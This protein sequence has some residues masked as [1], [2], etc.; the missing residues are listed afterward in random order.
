MISISGSKRISVS[1]DTSNL[2][3]PGP[4]GFEVRNG[5]DI[6]R[7]ANFETAAPGANITATP[8][9]VIAPDSYFLLVSWFPSSQIINIGLEANLE[10]KTIP[11]INKLL[12]SFDPEF[13]PEPDIKVRA[14][15]GIG[16]LAISIGRA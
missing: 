2:L 6:G 7:R 5:C 11:E 16:T 8:L 13:R 15:F 10:T 4:S 14:K 3:I 1:K 9:A 12:V